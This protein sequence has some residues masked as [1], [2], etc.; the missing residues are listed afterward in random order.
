MTK[1]V[2][3]RP[4]TF[5]EFRRLPDWKPR[6][7]AYL[8]SCARQP[9]AEG[10]HDC[11]LFAAGAVGAMTG[12]DPAARWR[13]K[14]QTTRRGLGLLKRAGFADHIALAVH[15][16]AEVH[17]A[18]ACAGDLAIVGADANDRALGVVQGEAVYLLRP[19]GLGLIHMAPD[20]RIL[21]V[22]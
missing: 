2:L 14:Y 16:F 22:T 15:L 12:N 1:A 17:P 4:V 11:A 3:T 5:P 7:A 18:F 20:V 19:T 10:R 6:L 8:S 21:R 13:G 9:F